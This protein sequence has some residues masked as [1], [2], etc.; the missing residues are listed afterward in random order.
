[1]LHVYALYRQ[2]TLMSSA[3]AVYSHNSLLK[4]PACQETATIHSDNAAVDNHSATRRIIATHD[5]V[6]DSSIF[7][8]H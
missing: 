8:H 2:N 5:N 1:M 6:R 4:S 3:F 7:H